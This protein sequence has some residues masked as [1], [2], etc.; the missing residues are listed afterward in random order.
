MSS[1]AKLPLIPGYSVNPPN[2]ANHAKK[3]TLRFANGIAVP[4]ELGQPDEAAALA[5]LQESLKEW[6]IP[7]A[8]AA[9][10]PAAASFVPSYV[11]LDK[12]VLRYHGWFKEPVPDSPLE[13]WRVRKVQLLYYLEDG[14]M[15]VTE[16]AEPNSGLVQGTL[17]R[18]HKIPRQGGGVLGLGDLA[19]GAAV[20]IYGREV[21]IVDADAFTREQ[22]VA[23]GTPLAPAQ[24]VPPNPIEQ[25]LAAKSKPSG[26]SRSDPDSPSKFAEALLG[27]EFNS[28]SLQQFLEH[29][30][31]VL[32][33]YLLWDIPAEQGGGRAR[34]KMHYFVADSTAEIMEVPEAGTGCALFPTFLK[35]GPLPKVGKVGGGLPGQARLAPE[36]CFT[37]AD[38]R[39]HLGYAASELA[40]LSVEEQKRDAPQPALPPWNGIGSPED[41]LQN[42]LKL[43]PKPPKKDQYRWQQLDHVVLRYEAVLEPS[44]GK[45]L[46]KIDAGRRF[47]MSFF[48]AD[49]TLAVFEPPQPNTGIPGGK[50]LERG[51][52]YKPGNKVAWLTED[53]LAV[54]ALLDLHGRRFRLTRAD[55]FTE[56]YMA[57]RVQ[58][59]S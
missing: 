5:A 31:E 18:R 51:R 14:S 32:R 43:V 49:Q 25:A 13:S 44:A 56:R 37:P 58:G 24:P 9:A 12:K 33:F 59:G 50:F 17:V 45:Q 48:M 34:F 22:A 29:G 20:N 57:E 7:S 11:A 16:P 40:P 3:Q 35:R 15:Q 47:V 54:G 2:P 38:L 39:E 36:D 10:A 27:R 19:V 21:A 28:K 42:C 30:G 23:R 8:G 4:V 6:R 52:V 41:S 46:I 26:L 55:A 53:D 1:P